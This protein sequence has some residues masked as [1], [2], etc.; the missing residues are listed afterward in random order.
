MEHSFHTEPKNEAKVVSEEVILDDKGCTSSNISSSPTT[1]LNKAVTTKY[2]QHES[3][4]NSFSS[5][6]H[7]STTLNEN[8]G[9]KYFA[10][11]LN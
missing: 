5:P 9:G 6:P 1:L 2:T 3:N 4:T 11:C 8:V 10:K 7:I